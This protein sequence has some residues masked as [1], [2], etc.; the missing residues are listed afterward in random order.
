[1]VLSRIKQLYN[2]LELVLSGVN[3]NTIKQIRRVDI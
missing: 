2:N 1:M 3:K